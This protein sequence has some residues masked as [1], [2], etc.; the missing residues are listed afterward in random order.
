[1]RYIMPLPAGSETDTFARVLSRR[2]AE[3]W[4]QQVVVENRPG[5][6]TTIGTEV[7]AKVAPNGYTVLHAITAHAINATLYPRLSYD[8]LKDFACITQIGSIYGVLVAHP[9]FPPNNIAELIALAQRRPGQITYASGGSGTSNHIA[10]EALR[11]AAKIDIVHVPYKGGSQAFLDLLP[12]RVPLLATVVLEA[13]PHIR[14]GKVKV[15]A[16]TSAKRAPSLPQVPTIAE[17]LPAYKSGTTFWALVT[18]SGTPQSV[19]GKL[20]TDVLKAMAAADVR[21]RL[22]QMDVESVGS[23]PEQCDAFLREQ[24]ALWGAVVKASGAR[25]D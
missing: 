11:L 7:A 9:S 20:N 18:R 10:G 8:A 17:S 15:I 1:V 23:S 22:A 4:D 2:L 12:G 5:G 14:S 6:G 25:V 21:E 16:S 3:L 19:I 13:L 24:V